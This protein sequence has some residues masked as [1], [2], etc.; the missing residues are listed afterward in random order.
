MRTRRRTL[1]IRVFVYS[2]YST[3]QVEYLPAGE[4]GLCT[5]IIIKKLAGTD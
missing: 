5:C 3:C 2:M 1:M 4:A